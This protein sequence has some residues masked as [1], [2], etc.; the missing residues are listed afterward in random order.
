MLQAN[1]FS[2]GLQDF[3][4]EV[5]P[6]SNQYQKQQAAA[7]RYDVSKLHALLFGQRRLL[8]NWNKGRPGFVPATQLAIMQHN[9]HYSRH[10][11]HQAHQ[12]MLV[13]PARIPASL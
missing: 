12:S 11:V 1:A 4:N 3:L 10:I 6:L 2:A 7:D 9:Q 5:R 8:A 13:G